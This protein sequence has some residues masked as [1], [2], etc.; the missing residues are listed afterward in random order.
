MLTK[1]YSTIA[2]LFA[3]N[4]I[5]GGKKLDDVP[6][7]FKADVQDLIKTVADTE[8]AKA[9]APVAQPTVT[10]NPTK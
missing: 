3:A 7:T 2:I 4:V 1:N 6:A 5:D 8:P 10:I 9:S